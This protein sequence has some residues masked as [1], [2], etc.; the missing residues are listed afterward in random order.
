MTSRAQSLMVFAALFAI[1]VDVFF[2]VQRCDA[3]PAIDFSIMGLT[4]VVQALS[5]LVARWS[6]WD[7]RVPMGRGFAR[8]A[9]LGA[10]LFL[11][12]SVFLARF[13]LNYSDAIGRPNWFKS[14][15]AQC[16]D[17]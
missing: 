15:G 14:I 3:S 1:A 11:A 7:H 2:Y 12:I 4:L 5:V 9:L 8:P 16:D 10:V 6:E 17:A 13:A